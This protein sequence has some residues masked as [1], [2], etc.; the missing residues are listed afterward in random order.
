M[1][2]QNK[3]KDLIIF[4]NCPCTQNSASIVF[5]EMYLATPSPLMLIWTKSDDSLGRPTE[6]QKLCNTLIP[7]VHAKYNMSNEI[8]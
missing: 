7:V 1:L 2:W 5:H 4:V 8:S 3:I 6:C